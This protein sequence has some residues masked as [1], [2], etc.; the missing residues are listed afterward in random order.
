MH[1]PLRIFKIKERSM[2]PELHEGDY[3]LVRQAFMKLSPG[4]IVVLR[5]PKKEMSIVK[6]VASA[7]SRGY[8]VRGDNSEHSEDS[9][10]F[11]RIGS[12]A[13]I[14]KVVCKI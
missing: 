13:I 9:R 4:D 6:R 3:V 12:E 7:G 11:G 10:H 5:H 14:G 2:E 8:F 1:F